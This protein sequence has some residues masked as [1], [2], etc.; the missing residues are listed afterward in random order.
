[1]KTRFEPAST[2]DFMKV[3][4]QA[5]DLK[6]KLAYL[7]LQLGDTPLAEQVASHVPVMADLAEALSE[8]M[9]QFL[10]WR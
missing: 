5:N 9:Q 7:A 3:I 1:M 8:D 10:R 2:D 4:Q 6:Y